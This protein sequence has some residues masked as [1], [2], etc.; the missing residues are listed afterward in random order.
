MNEPVVL[1]A[2]AFTKTSEAL[3]MSR[4]QG[5]TRVCS[6]H[7]FIRRIWQSSCAENEPFNG[8][9]LLSRKETRKTKSTQARDRIDLYQ[10]VAYK[11]EN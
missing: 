6:G 11:G 7:L 10:R 1:A 5:F 3:G 9:D 4:S 8:G 2:Q